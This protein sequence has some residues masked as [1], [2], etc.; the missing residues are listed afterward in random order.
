[1]AAAVNGS[2]ASPSADAQFT[3]ELAGT[4]VANGLVGRVLEGMNAWT[5]VITLFALLVAYDQSESRRSPEP[6]C[7]SADA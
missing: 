3:P 6:S 1:M 7:V 5:V 2:F 4:Q